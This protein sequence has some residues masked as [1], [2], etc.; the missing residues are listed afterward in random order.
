M[1]IAGIGG[2]ILVF[3]E[4]YV[5][6]LLKNYQTIDFGGIG[7]FISVWAMNFFLLFTIFT[8]LKL[9]FEERERTK[10]EAVQGK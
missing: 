4:S 3:I 5:V 10:E 6:L 8:H 1:T 7:P 9:W 2:F